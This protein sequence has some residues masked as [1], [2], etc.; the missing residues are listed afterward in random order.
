MDIK[1][2]AWKSSLTYVPLFKLIC[3]IPSLLTEDKIL[4]FWFQLVCV[5]IMF[6]HAFVES[7]FKLWIV[8]H[9]KIARMFM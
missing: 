9:I 1:T 2:Q 7:S 6:S 4:I 8:Y 3:S 5:I